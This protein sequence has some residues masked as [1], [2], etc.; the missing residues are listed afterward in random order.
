MPKNPEAFQ[1]STPEYEKF[2][3]DKQQPQPETDPKSLGL[4]CLI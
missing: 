1:Q 3:K 2:I 4:L